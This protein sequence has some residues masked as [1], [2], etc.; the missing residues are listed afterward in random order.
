MLRGWIVGVLLVL[1]SYL[2]VGLNLMT[3][4]YQVILSAIYC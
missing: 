4:Q 2:R 1:G 3:S